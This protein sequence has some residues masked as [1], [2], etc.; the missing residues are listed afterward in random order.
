M[1]MIGLALGVLA[2]AVWATFRAPGA[3]GRLL[4]IVLVVVSLGGLALGVF[5][6][7]GAWGQNACVEELSLVGPF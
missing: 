7:R 1:V 4:G 5:A 3:V 6:I 2:L